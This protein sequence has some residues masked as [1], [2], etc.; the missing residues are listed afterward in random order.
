[1][2]MAMI[3]PKLTVTMNVEEAIKTAKPATETQKSLEIRASES[4]SGVR[5]FINSRKGFINKY[6]YPYLHC[7]LVH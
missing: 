3:A 2:L 7:Y 1:M 5:S 6:R 4:G